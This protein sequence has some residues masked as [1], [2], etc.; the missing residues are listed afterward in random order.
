MV[1]IDFILFAHQISASGYSVRGR[2]Q[3]VRV[4]LTPASMQATPLPKYPDTKIQS[5]EIS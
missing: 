4:G 1:I 2:R 5:A 3:Y